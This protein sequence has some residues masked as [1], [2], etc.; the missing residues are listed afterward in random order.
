MPSILSR[1][2]ATLML[3]A[4]GA[5]LAGSLEPV[6]PEPLPTVQ[7]APAQTPRLVFTLRGGVAVSPEYFGS[8][9]YEI[10]PDLGFSLGYARLGGF[11]FG[12]TDPNFEKRGLN[13]RGAF[14]YIPERSAS[15][16]PAL[17]GLNDRD[18]SVELGLGL[19]YTQRNY[20]VFGDIR[21]G[22]VGHESFVGTLG[23]DL[24]LHPTDR[25]TVTAG[26]RVSL[27]S[28]TFAN[29][30]FGV[31][32]AEA[33]A[34]SFAA[35]EAQGGVMSA[36]VELGATYRINDSWGV[37]GAATYEKLMGDAADSPITQAG[38][39][40]QWRLRLG[41]TRRFSLGF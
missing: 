15:K 27:G 26:P 11:S 12:S 19:G 35:Y 39:D 13:L 21:Y 34:S 23:A 32:P 3:L 36:G 5:A 25:L 37:E 33:A 14:R 29:T 24:R 38:D 22:V 6:Q 9:D 16:S 41:L 17:A 1:T 8:S 30:Y 20:E 40:D 10:G 2:V 31:T 28:D 4:P 18:A 7:A